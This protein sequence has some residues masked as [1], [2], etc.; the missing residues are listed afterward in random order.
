MI[1]L[2]SHLHTK[3]FQD[4]QASRDGQERVVAIFTRMRG[5][6]N[7]LPADISPNAKE[8]IMLEVLFIL[9]SATIEI[10]RGGMSRLIRGKTSKLIPGWRLPFLLTF[11]SEKI[12]KRLPGKNKVDKAWQ[13]LLES[14]QDISAL[15]EFQNPSANLIPHGTPALVGEPRTLF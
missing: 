10:K 13:K 9:T 3:F 14:M 1:R 15:K 6:F 11:V 2:P 12:L 5:S 4:A 8:G 7:L